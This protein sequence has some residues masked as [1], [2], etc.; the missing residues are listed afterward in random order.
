MAVFDEQQQRYTNLSLFAED[1][2]LPA[3][4]VDGLQV[5]LS[6][7]ELRRARPFGNCWLAGE[8]WIN[9]SWAGS[10]AR[11]LLAVGRP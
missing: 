10:G 2:P 8:L 11:A 7:L 1:R 6:G 9:S 3:G 5:R 4:A